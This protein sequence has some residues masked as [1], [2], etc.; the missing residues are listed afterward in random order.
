MLDLEVRLLARSIALTGIIKRILVSVTRYSSDIC[1][2][3]R[4]SVYRVIIGFYAC[5]LT[6]NHKTNKR[7]L[8]R[9]ENKA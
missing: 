9:S 1:P 4:H 5:M 3:D 7:V 2:L 6:D 8:L